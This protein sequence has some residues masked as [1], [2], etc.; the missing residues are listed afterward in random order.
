[1]PNKTEQSMEQDAGDSYCDGVEKELAWTRQKYTQARNKAEVFKAERDRL[2]KLLHQLGSDQPVQSFDAKPPAVRGDDVALHK[3]ISSL[4]RQR[5]NW[6]LKYT[7]RNRDA[8]DAEEKIKN[9]NTK[10][11]NVEQKCIKLTQ[12]LKNAQKPDLDQELKQENTKLRIRLS[13]VTSEKSSISA[14]LKTVREELKMTRRDLF[15]EKQSHTVAMQE[16]E[17]RTQR[18]SM[19]NKDWGTT[20]NGLGL[21]IVSG[22]NTFG[23]KVYYVVVCADP[24]EAGLLVT[25]Q[26]MLDGPYECLRLKGVDRVYLPTLDIDDPKKLIDECGAGVIDGPLARN[27]VKLK[28]KVKEHVA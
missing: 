16:V 26:E 6:K 11:R 17:N 23:E 21:Y 28:P 4:T 27:P 12:D 18:G 3:K 7:V 2:Q 22:H 15:A 20:L 8:R 5:N 25:V 1:M 19:Q 14:Q 13:A 9:L 10:V 24:F